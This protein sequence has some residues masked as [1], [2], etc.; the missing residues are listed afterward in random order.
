MAT[1]LGNLAVMGMKSVAAWTTAYAAVDVAI[2][3]IDEGLV[4]AFERIEKEAKVGSAGR[5]PSEQGNLVVAGPVNM[6]MDYNNYDLLWQGIFGTVASGVYTITDD[7][8]SKYVWIEV[9]KGVERWRF[10]ASK[11]MK[12]TLTGEKNGIVKASADY[13]CRDLQ[14][15]AAAF[16]GISPATQTK[17]RFNDLVFRIADQVDAIAGGDAVTIESFEF[18]FDRGY[19]D[20]DYVNAPNV[21]EPVPGDWRALTLKFRSPRYTGTFFQDAKA[22]DTPLQADLIFT[23]GGESYKLELPE[24]EIQSGF[25]VETTGP[26]PYVLEGTLA[27]KRSSNA[28]MFTGNEAKLTIV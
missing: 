12:V 11:P 15:N 2:P 18:E 23:R 19:K 5:E 20:D 24:L 4:S 9:D 17:I 3:F 26:E 13:L 27:C 10:G 22:A 1:G 16:P 14:R 28:F 6:E 8:V 25:D 7:V 21:L